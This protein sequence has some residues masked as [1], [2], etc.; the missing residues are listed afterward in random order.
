MVGTKKVLIALCATLLVTGVQAQP[1]PF[2]PDRSFY[3][4]LQQVYPDF[5]F[6]EDSAAL[7]GM[8]FKYYS[9]ASYLAKVADSLRLFQDDSSLKELELILDLTRKKFLAQRM[10][11]RAIESVKITDAEAEEYYKDH[12]EQFAK[13]G[14]ISYMI[15]YATTDSKEVQQLVEA[16]LKKYLNVPKVTSENLK[17]VETETF[18]VTADEDMPLAPG[19]RFYDFLANAKTNQVIGPFKYIDRYLYFLPKEIIPEARLP[20]QEVKDRC[21]QELQAQKAMSIQAVQ[22]SLARSWFP[23]NAVIQE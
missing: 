10:K 7:D 21:V 20:F 13:P 23:I 15:A 18:V 17:K 2:E 9:E 19:E 22:D 5:H 4:A 11:D 16:E 14:R 8:L 6:T 12:A 3:G 1:T